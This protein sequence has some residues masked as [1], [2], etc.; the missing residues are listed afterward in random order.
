MGRDSGLLG[1]CC[2]GS[3]FEMAGSY[4][5]ANSIIHGKECTEAPYGCAYT[6]A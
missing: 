3:G 2:W 4:L 5:K 6:G 1:R